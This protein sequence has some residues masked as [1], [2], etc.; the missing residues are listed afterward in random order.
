MERCLAAIAVNSAGNI[1][2]D[3]RVMAPIGKGRFTV[4]I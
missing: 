2:I 3:G 1:G 4:T